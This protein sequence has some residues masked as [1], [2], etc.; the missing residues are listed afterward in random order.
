M[1]VNDLHSS[2][3]FYQRLGLRASLQQGR[4]A[5]YGG[6]AEPLIT[7]IEDAI[8]PRAAHRGAYH[9]AIAVP[10]RRALAAI[11]R[12]IAR[13]RIQVEGFADHGVSEALYLPDAEGIGLEFCWD[14][15]RDAWYEGERLVI[16]TDP[17]D[18]DDLLREPALPSRESAFARARIG[19]VH[20]Y[21]QDVA[22]DV[23]FYETLGMEVM[24]RGPWG[25]FVA[26]DGYHHHVGLRRGRAVDLVDHGLSIVHA[27]IAAEWYERLDAQEGPQGK[28]LRAPSGHA[29]WVK[30][31]A[32]EVEDTDR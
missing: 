13:E 9:V 19:H 15:P 2:V 27:R 14:R 25:T 31:L 21:A 6:G 26:A 20:L 28:V 32:Y 16:G 30:P 24:T 7:L 12:T 29:W 10:E 8:A 5:L 4:A 17:L 18:L 23:R 3:A 22:A 1:R 11:L